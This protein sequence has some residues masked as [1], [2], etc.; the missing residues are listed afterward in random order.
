MNISILQ[1]NVLIIPRTTAIYASE[2]Y[3]ES[4]KVR[5]V[6]PCKMMKKD[7]ILSFI[8]CLSLKNK[9]SFVSYKDKLG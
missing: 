7:R 3:N 9:S 4:S 8:L 6:N 1:E 5:K 2:R